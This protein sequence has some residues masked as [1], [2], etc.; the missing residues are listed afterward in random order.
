MFIQKTNCTNS[1]T[2]PKKHIKAPDFP[3]FIIPPQEDD[4]TK[5]VE[6][7]YH[8]L[9]V[10]EEDPIQQEITI[11]HNDE[12]LTAIHE[13]IPKH[14]KYTLYIQEFAH[15]QGQLH[16]VLYELRKATE[17]DILE[18]RINSPG[19]L[20]SEGIILFN[21]MREI[22]N[23][24]TITYNDSAG[25]SMGAMIFSLGDERVC[26][27]DSSLMY[28]NYSTAYWGKGSEIKSYVDYEDQHFD[29]FFRKKIVNKGYMTED[30]Y[31][32]M[33]KGV[34]F[35][36]DSYEMAKRGICTHVIVSGYKLD[37]EAYIEFHD[38]DKSIGDWAI[39]KLI[40]LQSKEEEKTEVKKVTP[41]RARKPKTTKS[42]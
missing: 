23:G 8:T 21:T 1:G 22:F 28:H 32:D 31:I 26:Y 27:E 42:K 38:Q 36:L 37:S 16:R 3:P 15:E 40:E 11:K 12:D 39:Q 2:T 25:Y 6:S 9:F 10:S 30:E 35:W 20:V 4:G 34:D 41:K 19:G 24:R 29:T 17:D 18:L 13:I 14:K 5:I 33:K 7:E